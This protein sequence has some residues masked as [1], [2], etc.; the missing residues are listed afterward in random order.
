MPK[1]EIWKDR[2]ENTRFVLTY[3]SIVGTKFNRYLHSEWIDEICKNEWPK[4]LPK[5]IS[6]DEPENFNGRWQTWMVK[7]GFRRSKSTR[8]PI[9]SFLNYY[10][11]CYWPVILI[12]WAQHITIEP[13]AH[14]IK[15]LPSTPKWR[16]KLSKFSFLM[17]RIALI[18]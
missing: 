4:R 9:L 3:L 10:A 7:Y 16:P 17:Q 18:F 1:V 12:E 2:M 14:S 6:P 15:R 11:I 5:Y 8:H 13:N